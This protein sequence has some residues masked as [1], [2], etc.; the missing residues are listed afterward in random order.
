MVKQ[1]ASLSYQAL[2]VTDS[3]FNTEALKIRPDTYESLLGK[4]DVLNTPQDI[5]DAGCNHIGCLDAED[6]V[7]YTPW[8]DG[9][10]YLHPAI[11]AYD[12]NINA[13]S[14]AFLSTEILNDGAPYC[15]VSNGILYITK[16]SSPDHILLFDVKDLVS[17]TPKKVS[18]KQVV[19]LDYSAV[20]KK[21]DHVQSG[22][23]YKDTLY[24][25]DDRN[26]IKY[27]YAIDIKTGKV[28]KDVFSFTPVDKEGNEITIEAE[29]IAFVEKDSGLELIL[30]GTYR[31]STLA[32]EII[33]YTFDVTE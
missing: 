11:V 15:A 22:K 24:L 28:S 14:Y 18:P 6:G 33:F 12:T 16:Y 4:Y 26:S 1:F 21:I 31:N 30:M 2:E 7:L 27:I 25:L 3:A 13:S 17:N 5:L 10:A 23:I 20:S 29:G 32:V 19:E 8:E 9:R